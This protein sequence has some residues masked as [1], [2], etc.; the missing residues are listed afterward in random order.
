[1]A[2]GKVKWFNEQKGFG[3]IEKVDGGE[4]FFFKTAIQEA[5]I[6]KLS[7]DQRVSFDIVHGPTGTVAEDIKH[8]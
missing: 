7:F 8:L 5:G 1:M 3:H 6:K 2:E 4:V